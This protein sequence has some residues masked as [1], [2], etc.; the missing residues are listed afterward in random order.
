MATLRKNWSI[1]AKF[2]RQ[3]LSNN[4]PPRD[5]IK[6]TSRIDQGWFAK[7]KIFFCKESRKA[8]N[9]LYN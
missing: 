3:H 9:L 1:A 7:Q 8:V 2:R 4:V 5:K 6:T